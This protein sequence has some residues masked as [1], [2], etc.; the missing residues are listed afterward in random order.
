MNPSTEPNTLT[1]A[2]QTSPR[3]GAWTAT[4]LV[5]ALIAACMGLSLAQTGGAL[6]ARTGGLM[7]LPLLACGLIVYALAYTY[8][9]RLL[10]AQQAMQ[11]QHLEMASAKD[12]AEAATEA[13]S[14]F[15]ANMSHEIRT[16]MNGVLGISHLLLDTDPSPQQLK[17]INTIDHSARN[18]LLILNDILDLSK[19]EANQLK[20]ENVRFDLHNTV[21]QTI[22]LFHTLAANKSVD[23]TLTMADDVPQYVNGDPVRFS[24]IL[25]NLLS[26]AV[27]FT[28]HGYVRVALTWDA[29]NQTA[30]CTIEDSGIGIA[31]E[32]QGQLFENF[33]QGDVSIARR[34]GGTGL[35]LAI[36]KRLA[37]SMGGRI[38]FSSTEGVGSTF[39]FSLPLVPS[40]APDTASAVNLAPHSAARISAAEA[41]VLVVDD[42]PVNQLLLTKLLL[43]FGFV[44]IDSAE[45]GAEALV[46]V[47][48]SPY[49]MVLMDG[50]MPVMDGY[51]ATR[52]I[53]AQE[54]A[55]PSPKHQLIVAM[56]ANAMP[57]DVEDCLAAGM[58]DYFSKPID[59]LK[60]EHFLSRWFI[61]NAQAQVLAPANHDAEVPIDKD[62]LLQV[63]QTPAELR[64]ITDLLFT[65]GAEKITEMRLHRRV[66]E[67]KQWANAAHYLRGAA[68][69]LGMKALSARC[70]EAEQKQSVGYEEKV[71]LVDA[72]QVEFDRA[73]AYATH[74]LSEMD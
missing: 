36:I 31:S 57:Q 23:L 46:A 7:L 9:R 56:T 26:N 22:N 38:G 32:K 17:Y 12:K 45:N 58:D 34:Y 1:P 53:R 43:K 13:K 67:Q 16:L 60:L 63:S 48:K 30:T 59:P 15:L 40:A 72:I 5:C 3:R 21:N 74:L 66:E 52:R 10:H 11:A 39:W 6:S 69:M 20:I 24:Q 28:E 14:Q 51:E 2:L 61:S 41:K 25:A 55:N 47:S 70:A 71:K 73:Q 42:H 50:Q 49:D 18:L 8:L 33:A 62:I 19:I 68:S 37:A 35:G 54:Q 27:K 44:N 4:L 65:L 64:H 29:D